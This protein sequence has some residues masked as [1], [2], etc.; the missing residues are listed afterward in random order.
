MGLWRS[1][2]RPY[3]LQAA[4]AP[5]D[6]KR[7]RWVHPCWGTGSFPKSQVHPLIICLFVVSILDAVWCELK[8][9]LL[10]VPILASMV[11][12]AELQCCWLEVIV[13]LLAVKKIMCLML[14]FACYICSCYTCFLFSLFPI[15]ALLLL[16]IWS[17]VGAPM[18][19][20]DLLGMGTGWA[21]APLYILGPWRGYKFGDCSRAVASPVPAPLPLATPTNVWRNTIKSWWQESNALETQT[22]LQK[23][24]Q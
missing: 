7:I 19:I 6:A 12:I 5:Q 2:L 22:T 23:T 21:F 17:S 18:G 15:L 14:K 4:I 9:S 3:G 8:I 1:R 11:W 20:R 16:L 10:I 24:S 13:V